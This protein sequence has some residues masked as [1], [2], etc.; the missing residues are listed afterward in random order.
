MREI[1][2]ILVAVIIGYLLG[3][4]GAQKRS[5]DSVSLADTDLNRERHQKKEEA[6]ARV[7]A[8]FQDGREVVNN[9]VERE[10]GVSDAT[11]TVYLS[12]LEASGDIVQ[13]GKEGRSV[14]YRINSTDN[15]ITPHN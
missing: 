11:A 14:V 12:E 4:R 9:D 5:L 10:L 2:T 13:I 6:K 1:L 3:R 7:L 15:S 8:M